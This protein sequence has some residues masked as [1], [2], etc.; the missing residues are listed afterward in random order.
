[1][2]VLQEFRLK[3]NND[4]EVILEMPMRAE[5]IIEQACQD[6]VS[7]LYDRQLSS[8]GVRALNDDGEELFRWTCEDEHLQRERILARSEVAAKK[9]LLDR[10]F[11]AIAAIKE[12]VALIRS[13]GHHLP[14]ITLSGR[15]SL[16][17]RL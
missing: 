14:R 10:L 9:A 15:S 1:M 8:Y 6:R 12:E 17:A 13:S 11:G 2:L 7:Y 3:M 5:A 16:K 4:I